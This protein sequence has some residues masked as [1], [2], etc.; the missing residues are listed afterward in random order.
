MLEKHICPFLNK[1]AKANKLSTFLTDFVLFPK[2]YQRSHY[3]TFLQ[4]LPT[5]TTNSP[6]LLPQGPSN[7]CIGLFTHVKPRSSLLPILCPCQLKSS[8]QFSSF[9]LLI[10]SREEVAKK[11]DETTQTRKPADQI[12]DNTQSYL[13]HEKNLL[14]A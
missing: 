11:A 1:F 4:H 9:S 6:V 13:L 7:N 10:Q 8:K 3:Q 2:W 14:S 12:T 5:T